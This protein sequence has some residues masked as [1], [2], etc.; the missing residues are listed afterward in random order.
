[1]D[2]DNSA[3]KTPLLVICRHKLLSTSCLPDKRVGIQP[4]FENQAKDGGITG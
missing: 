2:E 4:V 3:I 1:M